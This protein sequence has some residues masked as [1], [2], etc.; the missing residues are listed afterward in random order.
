MY[1]IVEVLPTIKWVKLVEKKEFIVAALDLDD[2][3]FIIYVASLHIA[4]TDIYPS[5]TVQIASL[6]QN[7][8]CIMVSF[9][10]TDYAD[11]FSLN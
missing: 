5:W 8:T 6:I 2:K 7:K 3:T 4:S 1:I 9:E 10:Y 11:I